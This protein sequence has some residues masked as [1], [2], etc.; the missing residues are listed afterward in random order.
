MTQIIQKGEP[1]NSIHQRP[2]Y[3]LDLAQLDNQRSPDY[4]AGTWYVRTTHAACQEELG[5]E[6]AQ[7]C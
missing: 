4:L 7:R 2:I 3:R 1:L 5:R 6:V